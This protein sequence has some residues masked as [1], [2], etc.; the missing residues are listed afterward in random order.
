MEG[1]ALWYMM[2][3][4]KRAVLLKILTG[5]IRRIIRDNGSGPKARDALL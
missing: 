5:R 4:M 1:F 3:V 2:E